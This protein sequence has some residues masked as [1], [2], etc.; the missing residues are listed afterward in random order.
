MTHTDI[1][2]IQKC[3]NGNR[4]AYELLV[5][6]YEK[7]IASR[8]WRFSRDPGTCEALVQEVFVD[9]FF[10]LKTYRSEAPFLNWLS[11]IATRVG[12]RHWKRET[13]SAAP[14]STQTYRNADDERANH[15]AEKAG[16]IVH[17]LLRHLEP[18][19]RLILTLMYFEECTAEEIAVRLNCSRGRIKMRAHRAKKRLRQLMEEYHG[20]D[21]T[22]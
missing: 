1:E 6:K 12:Y 20:P 16:E 19:D 9:A 10:S 18:E 21:Q 5:R 22:I 8:M 15:E 17:E 7:Q 4:N 13:A 14:V 2:I 3:L 11:R